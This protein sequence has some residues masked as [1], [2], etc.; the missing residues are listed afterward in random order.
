M[1][2]KVVKQ[3]PSTLMVSL[4][5]K[6]VKKY[7]VK[8]G[9]EVEVDDSGESLKLLLQGVSKTLKEK[10]LD[11]KDFE[12]QFI[13]L[14]L[15]NLYRLGFDKLNI[16]FDS[17]QQF[18][19]IQKLS[20]NHFLGFEVTQKRNDYCVIEN[21]TEPHEEKYDVLLRRIFLIIKESLSQI[22]NDF[23]KRDYNLLSLLIQQYTKIDQFVNF[24]MRNVNKS[25]LTEKSSMKYLFLYDLLIMSSELEHMYG[26]IDKNKDIKISKE[27]IKLVKRIH[28]VFERFYD[29]FYKKDITRLSEINNE[30]KSL[31]YNDAYRSLMSSEVKERVVVYHLTMFIRY[32]T[33]IISPTIGI[34]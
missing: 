24:C 25:H 19:N 14:T 26:F 16:K 21:V 29:S 1:K 13:K 27:V 28:T 17:I 30:A 34:I 11:L 23:E 18:E 5:S 22:E 9:D 2:R 15:N 6:W 32:M 8:K 31:L 4:P 10:D 20:N 33:L 3:G 12:F 7:G